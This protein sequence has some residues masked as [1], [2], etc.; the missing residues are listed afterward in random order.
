MLLFSFF[1]STTIFGFLKEKN[2]IDLTQFIKYIKDCNDSINYGRDKI[3]NAHPFICV[4]IPVY[5]M[6]NYISKNLLNIINQSFQDFEI[7]M[8]GDASEDN[9][10]SIINIFQIID[11][12]IISSIDNNF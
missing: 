4:A 12:K 8:V 7:V 10:K 9:S 11:F 3:Y 6:E 1:T 2:Y 5:N